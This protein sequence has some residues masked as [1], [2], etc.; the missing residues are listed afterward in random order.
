MA[1]SQLDKLDALFKHQLENLQ[2]LKILGDELHSMPES[3]RDENRVKEISEKL[4]KGVN[5]YV[6]LVKDVKKI[7]SPQGTIML[8]PPSSN[9]KDK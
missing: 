3:V 5:E 7:L 1:E 4:D 9:R 6:D 2:K 8:P